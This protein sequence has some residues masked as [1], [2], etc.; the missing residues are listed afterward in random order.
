MEITGFRGALSSV[1]SLDEMTFADDTGIWLTLR[2][3]SLDWNRAALLT[4][5]I[6]INQLRAGQIV[7]SRTP[8]TAAPHTTA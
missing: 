5:R 4:G 6:S 1:A 7:I 8:T 3:V 2:D